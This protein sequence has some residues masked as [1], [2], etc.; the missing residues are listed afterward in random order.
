MFVLSQIIGNSV[1]GIPILTAHSCSLD[2]TRP[3]MLVDGKAL[4]STDLHRR[5]LMSSV[6]VTRD[7]STDRD[8]LLS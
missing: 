2:I 3:M 1:L 8:I 7:S 4:T 5:M 6:Q